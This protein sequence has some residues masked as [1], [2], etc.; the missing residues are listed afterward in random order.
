MFP[1]NYFDRELAGTVRE[2]Q[3][4]TKEN[5]VLQNRKKI[6]KLYNEVVHTINGG[7]HSFSPHLE[8]V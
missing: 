2:Q 6:L 8:I 5:K 7:F 3:S 4:N 1:P